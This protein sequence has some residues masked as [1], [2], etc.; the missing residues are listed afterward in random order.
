MTQ[1][2]EIDAKHV[3]KGDFIFSPKS[4]ELLKVLDFYL[5]D[6]EHD[7]FISFDKAEKYHRFSASFKVHI[8][9]NTEKLHVI[10]NSPDAYA[11]IE[12][13]KGQSL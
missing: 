11:V 4:R 9:V 13:G 3:Q 12:L 8:L 10:D 5:K 2:I 7:V 1:L 6:E